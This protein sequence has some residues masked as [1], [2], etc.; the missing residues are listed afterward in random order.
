[1]TAHV[2]GNSLLYEERATDL[3]LENLRHYLDGHDLL[4]VYN[5]DRGY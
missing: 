2:A 4:N 3:F 1:M 5:P